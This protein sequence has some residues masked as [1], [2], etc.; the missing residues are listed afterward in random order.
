[1]KKFSAPS[2]EDVSESNQQI[3]DN[4][5]KNLGIVPN[6]Y[7]YFGKN[8]TALADYLAL[9]S[10]KN[11]LTAKEREVVSLVVSQV[12]NCKY[13]LAGHTMVAKMIGFT[14]DQVLEIRKGVISFDD[15]LAALAKFVRETA[16]NRGEPSADSVESLFNAGFTEANL[17]DI[18]MATGDKV[19]SNYLH[20]ITRLPLDFPSAPEL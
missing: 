1:M 14:D 3:F 2:R 20:K 8:E 15:K 10:R 19:I 4:L 9:Q 5:Q 13:C 12:N 6:L 18:V 11:T 17:I 16:V 7:A